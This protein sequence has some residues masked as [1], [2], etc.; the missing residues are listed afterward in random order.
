MTDTTL[1]A[2]VRDALTAGATRAETEQVLLA[3]GWSSDQV[4]EA[5]SAWSETAFVVPVPLPRPQLSARDAFLYLVMFGMLY[6]SAY[7]FGALLFRFIE[8]ALPD[9]AYPTYESAL[10]ASLRFSTSTLIVAFPLFLTIATL[11][12]RQ[13]ARDP[14]Q[15]LSAVRRWLT[16]LTLAL[17]ACIL[18]GDAIYLLNSLLS[19]ELSLR[20]V[21]K[22]AVVGAIAAALFLYYLAA[23]RSD[24]EALSS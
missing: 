16:Y 9:A 14:A 10:R 20:I 17:A 22:T 19:G 1:A 21:L 2:F 5:L 23:M 24:N 13:L 6:L 8:L 3:S 11:L 15:R 12:A 7:H 4:T 18:V